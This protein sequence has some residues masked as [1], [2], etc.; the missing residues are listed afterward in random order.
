MSAKRDDLFQLI[1]SMSKSEKRYFKME[2][3]KAGNKTSNHIKLF[4][5][6]NNLEEYDEEILKKKL[7][8]EKFIDHLSAE[9]RYLYQAVLRSIRN[10]RGDQ[11]TFAQIKTMVIDANYLLER[12]L[13]DQAAKILDKAAKL[14]AKIDDSV[15][16]LEINLTR[17]EFS[18]NYK[19]KE[20]QQEI[21]ALM[22]DKDEIVE[23][24]L[25]KLEI[26]DIYNKIG[27]VASANNKVLIL[28][29]I[30][31]KESFLEDAQ[32]LDSFFVKLWRYGIMAHYYKSYG[33]LE[34]LSEIRSNLVAL[35]NQYP[36]IKEEL[37]Y[38]YLLHL[39]NIIS[40][41]FALN[42]MDLAFKYLQILEN[43]E[44]KNSYERIF[45]FERVA[46]KKL[47]Y[48]MS[49][50][51]FDK[52][53]SLVPFIE[54]ALEEY[55]M[56]ASSSIAIKSNISILFFC[57]EEFHS[58]LFWSNKI[59]NTTKTNIRVDI[60]RTNRLRAIIAQIEMDE[61]NDIIDNICR[62]T[63]RYLQKNGA[64]KTNQV[65]LIILDYLWKYHN[66][67]Q[68]QK[69]ELLSQFKL[70]IEEF[71][72]HP[73]KK[74]ILVLEEIHFWIRSKLEKKPMAQL[75]KESYGSRN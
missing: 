10:Y 4:D 28:D 56:R 11:S 41:N 53:L 19:K 65:E 26:R 62:S 27:S 45:I 7:K 40:S 44:P 21:E 59:I 5:A 23:L 72:N 52:A 46:I 32:Y 18:R 35:W 8:K 2:S 49:T 64:S 38:K 54:S 9:K 6:I 66:M 37:H 48:F 69:E 15:S 12:S 63:K 31:G 3:K 67:L 55:P 13:H 61:D 58:C 24:L 42:Q 68:T 39:S 30:S 51:N 25:T 47:I 29:L 17:Q 73:T 14:A 1:Q 75:I 50:G 36:D 70:K 22:K 16:L 71:Q 60:Q 34:K 20:H 57:I 33:D 74:L 43:E